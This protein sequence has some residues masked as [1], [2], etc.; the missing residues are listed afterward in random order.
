ML[1]VKRRIRLLDGTLHQYEITSWNQR[2]SASRITH[3][4]VESTACT[5]S[6]RRMKHNM[7]NISHS[8]NRNR[9][10]S[11]I[12]YHLYTIAGWWIAYAGPAVTMVHKTDYDTMLFLCNAAMW[13]ADG[14]FETFAECGGGND[15]IRYDVAC[16]HRRWAD[17]CAWSFIVDDDDGRTDDDDYDDDNTNVD[18]CC[19]RRPHEE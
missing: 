18:F 16:N 5:A 9:G 1:Y 19:S 12:M 7:N 17:A 14:G 13:Y 6:K 11:K 8:R 4:S 2:H 10:G 15:T 3:S